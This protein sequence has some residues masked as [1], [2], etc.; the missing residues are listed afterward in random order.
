M[1][2]LVLGYGKLG[3]EIVNQTG[4]DY[5]SRQKDNIDINNFDLWVSKILPYDTIV[6]CVANTN[7]YSDDGSYMMEVNYKFVV[8]LVDFCNHLGKKLVHI[9]T[10]YVYANSVENSSE[11]DIPIHNGDWYSYSKLMADTYVSNCCEKHLICRLSHKP[12]PFPYDS[13]WVDVYTNADYT[14]VITKLVVD[15]I[16]NEAFGL[17]NVGTK[18]KSIFELASQTKDVKPINGPSHVP[19]NVTMNL[20]KL[21]NFFLSLYRD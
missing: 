20:D 7:T 9:S 4:W 11:D 17:Y 3:S 1:K 18:T 15:L 8:N 21:D 10:D 16:K 14:P 5:L 13:A 19:K 2:V 6:N 12:H